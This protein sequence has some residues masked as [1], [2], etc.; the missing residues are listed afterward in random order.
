MSPARRAGEPGRERREGEP[1]GAAAAGA[2]LAETLMRG[3]RK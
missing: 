1:T 2:L 3:L